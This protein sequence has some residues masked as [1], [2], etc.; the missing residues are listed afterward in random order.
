[1]FHSTRLFWP[2]EKSNWIKSACNYFYAE[3][4]TINW[5]SLAVLN[6]KRAVYDVELSPDSFLSITLLLTWKP[7]I[8]LIARKQTGKISCT[9][10]RNGND[11]SDHVSF[12]MNKISVIRR[13][14]N[15]FIHAHAMPCICIRNEE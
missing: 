15:N 6:R 5:R 9:K 3:K 12:K 7:C 10:R 8:W 13:L 14:V 11:F 2:D 1:M 4:R